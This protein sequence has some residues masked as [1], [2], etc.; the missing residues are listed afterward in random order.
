MKTSR[1]GK[2]VLSLAIEH[3]Y[4]HGYRGLIWTLL[5]WG[6]DPNIKDRNGDYPLLQILYGG[7][8]PLEEHQRQALALILD[9][10]RYPT[11]VNVEPPGTLNMPL[12][13]AVRRKDPWAVGMLLEKGAI[14]GARNGAG[15]TPLALAI[16]TWSREMTKD[17][18]EV[19][20][21][22]LARGADPNETFGASQSPALHS[23]IKNGH[24][25]LV[26]L[27]V[28]YSADPFKTDN[29]GQNAYMLCNTELDQGRLTGELT[30]EI[31]SVL[32][33]HN[34]SY[35]NSDASGSAA[36]STGLPDHA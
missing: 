13:L 9:K 35:W 2:T 3:Q 12:H 36:D 14:Y 26:E 8:D 33:L 29:G 15:Q 5:N 20:R 31:R 27:L 7:Y 30:D 25:D 34:D 1:T 17:H 10:S 24:T 16:S 4:F 22:L 32:D 11:D 19:S 23:A 6:A 18:K 28:R 21:L